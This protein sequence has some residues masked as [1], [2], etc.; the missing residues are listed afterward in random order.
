MYAFVV[1]LVGP[2]RSPA[3]GVVIAY[4]RALRFHATEIHG[5]LWL[6]DTALAFAMYFF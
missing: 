1:C 6:R 5:L 2:K 4:A 3:R